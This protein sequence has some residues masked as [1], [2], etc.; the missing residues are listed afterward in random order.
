MPTREIAANQAKA[1]EPVCGGACGFGRTAAMKRPAV[2]DGDGLNRTRVRSLFSMRPAPARPLLHARI[3]V[4]A[5]LMLVLRYPP[6]LP[7]LT[8]ASF[9]CA[10]TSKY[11]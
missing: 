8:R 9:S 2:V 4:R 5:P 10:G 11:C 1:A 7:A 6:T 3:A